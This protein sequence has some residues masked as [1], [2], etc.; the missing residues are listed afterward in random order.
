MVVDAR[1]MPNNSVRLRKRGTRIL[2]EDLPV[3]YVQTVDGHST[4]RKHY[5]GLGLGDRR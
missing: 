3:E 1:T 4:G 2:R 5:A